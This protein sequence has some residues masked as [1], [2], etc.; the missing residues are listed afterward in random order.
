MENV[1]LLLT[2]ATMILTIA[3]NARNAGRRRTGFLH[4][5]VR[6]LSHVLFHTGEGECEGIQIE[7]VGRNGAGSWAGTIRGD[8]CFKDHALVVGNEATENVEVVLLFRNQVRLSETE[9]FRNC[10]GSGA[11]EGL[12]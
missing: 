7:I 10:R 1:S 3:R 8:D 4:K 12:H 5:W 11:G 6:I 9:R 2:A